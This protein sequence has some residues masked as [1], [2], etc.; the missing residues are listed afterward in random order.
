M[1][2]KGGQAGCCWRQVFGRRWYAWLQQ[3][4]PTTQ[5]EPR[6][7]N[8]EDD[9]DRVLPSYI[10]PRSRTALNTAIWSVYFQAYLRSPALFVVLDVF[11]WFLCLSDY[12]L[13]IFTSS[14]PTAWHI[15][16][17][18]ANPETVVGV[19]CS[20]ICKCSCR[21]L[22]VLLLILTQRMRLGFLRI[23]CSSSVVALVYWNIDMTHVSVVAWWYSLYK[24]AGN[25]VS[26]YGVFHNGI[27]KRYFKNVLTKTATFNGVH[28]R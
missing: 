20:C 14:G 5:L 18:S 17:N 15:G 10:T 9:D 2:E 13:R 3:S 27:S 12:L 4:E 7:F 21:L 24:L 11:F 26:S 25:S 28:F 16:R 6:V 8:D 1:C 23:Y 22:A 19:N